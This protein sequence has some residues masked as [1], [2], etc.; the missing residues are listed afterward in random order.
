MFARADVQIGLFHVEQIAAAFAQKHPL[1]P[2]VWAGTSILNQGMVGRIKWLLDIE[3][4]VRFLSLEPL[5]GPIDLAPVL[6][7][8]RIHWVIVGGHSGPNW[9]A[10]AMDLSWVEQ[11]VADCIGFN[12]PVHIKQDH[13][14][15]PGRQGRIPDDLWKFKEMPK[16]AR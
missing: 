16:V 4:S 2:N 6:A 15:H 5:W 12:I 8:G 3:A 10:H 1:P 7:T 14:P 9:K 11:I 13:D